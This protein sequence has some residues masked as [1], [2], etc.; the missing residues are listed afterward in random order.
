[1]QK[2]PKNDV[3]ELIN[4]LIIHKRVQNKI[5][6]NDTL[7]IKFANALVKVK[8]LWEKIVHNEKEKY[9][10]VEYL[11]GGKAANIIKLYLMFAQRN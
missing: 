4:D 3:K 11:E 2:Q 9:E 6:N 7:N 8:T 1:M 5:L 10:L